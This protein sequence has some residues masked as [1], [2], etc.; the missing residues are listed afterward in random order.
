[1][2]EPVA[3]F[4]TDFVPR[5]IRFHEER[6]LLAELCLNT[7]FLAF[8]GV[9]HPSLFIFVVVLQLISGAHAPR[10]IMQAWLLRYG[11]R[12]T[13]VVDDIVL[14]RAG[15]SWRV[16]FRFTSPRGVV[17]VKRKAS[18][19]DMLAIDRRAAFVGT[20][21]GPL[22]RDVTVYFHP[23]WPQLAIIADVASFVVRRT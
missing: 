8:S 13:A 4:S 19:A 1:L 22:H 10:W 15:R 11:A 5:R 14:D 2:N 3:A 9:A 12:A 6:R 21:S 20:A 18:F 23:R 7:A 16:R 17:V